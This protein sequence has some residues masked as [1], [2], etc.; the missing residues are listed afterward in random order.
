MN[1]GKAQRD[2]DRLPHSPV[3]VV[4]ENDPAVRDSL[5]FSLEVEGFA[6]HLYCDGKELLGE[7]EL[8]SVDCLVVD[9]NLPDMSAIKVI[10][11]LRERRVQAPAIVMTSRPDGIIR[12][13]AAI[14][15]IQIVEKPL[16]GDAVL[17][18][19]R[20][21]LSPSMSQSGG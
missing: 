21:A 1:S 14:A 12:D 13:G 7:R 10:A 15:G 3:L 9:D 16:V 19:I 18:R 20:A 4:V 2:G 8:A 17:E 6:V 5:R 11:G